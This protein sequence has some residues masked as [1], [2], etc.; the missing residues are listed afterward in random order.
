MKPG[1]G[2]SGRVAYAA[3]T[4][5]LHPGCPQRQSRSELPFDASH[6]GLQYL[7]PSVALQVQFA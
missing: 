3:A 4:A 7:L 5:P 6:A 2:A 1:F